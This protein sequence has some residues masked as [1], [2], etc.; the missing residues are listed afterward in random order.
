MNDMRCPPI[1][2]AT[3][4][5]GRY[6]WA[7]VGLLFAATAINYIERQMIGLLK[8]IMMEDLALHMDERTYAAIV[9]WFQVA[10]AIG[11]LGFGKIVDA[12]GARIGYAAAVI[13]W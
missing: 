1:W 13:I 12:I 5:V 7:I 3:E 6:R 4:R 2:A 10:Y 11:Y 9:V 8:P